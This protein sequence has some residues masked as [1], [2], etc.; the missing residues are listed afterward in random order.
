MKILLLESIH[1]VAK[2]Y[3]EEQGFEV[4]LLSYAPSAEELP[5]LLADYQ[6]VGIRSKTKM[7]AEVLANSSHLLSICCFCIGTNQIDLLEAKK[8]GIAVFNAPHSNTRSVAELVLAEMVVLARQIGDRNTNAHKGIWTKSAT[9]ANEIRGKSLGIIGYG[10][11]GSQVSILAEAFGLNVYFYDINKKLPLGNAKSVGSMDELLSL[12]DFV[13]LHV[14]ETEQTTGMFTK[15]ELSL[16]KKGSYLINASRGSVIIIDDLVKALDTKHLAGCA[17]DV[18]PK[19]PASNEE[20]FKSEL[21]GKTNVILTPHIGGSTEEAQLS[22]GQEVAVSMERF[23]KTGSSV[24][25]VNLPNVDLPIKNEAIRIV[26]IHRNVPG[27]LGKINGAISKAGSNI[28]GQYLST[29][30]HIGYLVFDVHINDVDSLIQKIS[31]LEESILTRV[32]E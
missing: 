21:Q 8:L 15:R 16:M 10:H 23:L 1:T 27:V 3:L 11:I 20:L 25:A 12:S 4:S 31:D 2:T 7:T 22:I 13:T 26:N 30:E 29:D 17:V 18:F 28:E 5:G 24:A 6:A 9:G 32:I 14:P 19:E